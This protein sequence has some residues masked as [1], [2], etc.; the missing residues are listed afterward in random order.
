M[1]AIFIPALRGIFADWV[2][3]SCV[4]PVS[5]FET[6]VN[7]AE[8]LHENKEL[9]KLIQRE[10]K[11]KR[12]S[13][14]A[15]YLRTEN[16]RFFS[17][18]VI[19]VYGGEPTWYPSNIR[20]D[21]DLIDAKQITDDALSTLGFLRLSGNERLFALDGQHRLAGIK[22]A[23]SEGVDIADDEVSFILVA[24]KNDEAGL[25]RTRRLFTTLN[26]HA[27][28]VSKG[29]IISLDENDIMAI[30]SR[31]LVEKSEIFSKKRI[32]IKT[33]NNISD[34]DI[35]S[36]TTIGNLYDV[37]SIV[38]S[39]IKGRVSM[40][41]LKRSKRPSDTEIEEYFQYSINFFIRL[42][43]A[44]SPLQEFFNSNKEENIVKK[45]RGEFGGNILFRPLGLII[46]TEVIAKI[47]ETKTI[48][49]AFGFIKKIPSDLSES[50]YID[51]FW[52]GKTS[53][54]NTKAKAVVR[55]MLLIDAGYYTNSSKVQSIRQKYDK[56][57][58]P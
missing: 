6:R 52:V 4:L 16:E 31:M 17:S 54:I 37:L 1:N 15:N 24:H 49:E 34:K 57:L 40:Q 39:K 12:G 48:D 30:V 32:A 38:F 29:E 46:V 28:A 22:N 58:N 47:C 33:T 50:P 51:A 25:Q 21:D 20:P 55:D 18:F 53:S 8:E 10:L 19:A 7:F 44:F 3:Y 2:Y 43:D 36:L 42:S 23:L 56:I 35:T 45:Y 26:K 9:S 13:E 5:E 41:T 11:T 14:I 27:V